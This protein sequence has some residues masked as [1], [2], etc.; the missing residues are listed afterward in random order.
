MSA[1]ISDESTPD[2]SREAD[3]GSDD[4]DET[5]SDDVPVLTTDSG[6]YERL[7]RRHDAHRLAVLLALDLNA[8]EDVE[9][10]LTDNCST[11]LDAEGKPVPVAD[12]RD[13]KTISRLCMAQKLLVEVSKALAIFSDRNWVA[14]ERG[15]EAMNFGVEDQ[16]AE[17][18]RLIARY[19]DGV[20]ADGPPEHDI[21][22]LSL[23]YMLKSLNQLA[24]EFRKVTYECAFSWMIRLVDESSRPEGYAGRVVGEATVAAALSLEAGAFGDACGANRD[25]TAETLEDARARLAKAYNKVRSRR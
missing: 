11:W 10:F 17:V 20:I 7:A 23:Q 12:P 1:I 3:T 14:L 21:E 9:D 18:M 13:P 4:F 15:V 16:R 22:T 2:K 24:P 6:F 19:R 5:D 8:P 25:G